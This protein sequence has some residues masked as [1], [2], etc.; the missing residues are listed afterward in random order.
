L[1]YVRG[2]KFEEEPDYVYLSSLAMA[3]RE[4]NRPTESFSSGTLVA[5]RKGKTKKRRHQ[6]GS[7]DIGAEETTAKMSWTEVRLGN[8]AKQK[9]S[10]LEREEPSTKVPGDS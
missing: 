6:R 9:L 1:E 10:K 5:V 8:T 2:L 3:C 7:P 4:S